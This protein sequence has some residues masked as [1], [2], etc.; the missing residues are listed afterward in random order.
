MSG[1]G[2]IASAW[3]PSNI[4]YDAASGQTLL[5]NQAQQIQNQ[6][7]PQRNQLLLD[8]GQQRLGAN[9]IEYM[10]RASEGLLG[11]PDE[12]SRAAAYPGVVAS[13]Q[14]YGFAKGAPT[15]YPGEA[16]L[17]SIAAMG[18]PS[19]EQYKLG[20]S[21]ADAR[22]FGNRWL[23]GSTAA[24]PGGGQGG[25]AVTAGPIEP[26][27][28]SRANAV[29]DGLMKRGLDYDTATAFAA[30]ALHESSANPNTGAGDAG[31]SHGL[32]QWRGD[33]DA[34]YQQAYGHSPDN[35]PLD[36]QLD[37]V[38]RELSGPE[39][40]ARG[41]ITQAEGPEGKAAQVSEAYL[42]PKDVA[43]EMARRSATAKQLAALGPA[44]AG[45][46]V[47]ARTGGTD[48]AGPPGVV[49]PPAVSTAPQNTL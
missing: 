39:S 34:A 22:G 43:A 37:F 45:G 20:E 47:A 16:K 41:R 3:A 24:A 4:L 5:A 21:A 25:G 1:F 2:N 10:A 49:P 46:G 14:R 9:E 28:V 42:R 11:L 17:R 23:T 12:A 13:L 40:L 6:Y 8:E 29:R 15:E 18:I 7:A 19:A 26:E 44:P 30:N 36:E 27:A 31:A 33:R 35:A 32:F 48:V 38:M